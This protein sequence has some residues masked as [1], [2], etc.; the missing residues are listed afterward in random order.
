MGLGQPTYSLK[1]PSLY[2]GLEIDCRV[3]HP[4]TG[5]ALGPGLKAA[6]V[7]HPYAPLGGSYDDPIVHLVGGIL[8]DQGYIVGVLNFRCISFKFSAGDNM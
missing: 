2:D 7:G 5:G 4:T 1:V 6:L 3:Y 8:L